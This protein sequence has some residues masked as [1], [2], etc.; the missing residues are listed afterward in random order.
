MRFI[1]TEIKDHKYFKYLFF[2]HI[3]LPNVIFNIWE[4]LSQILV[5]RF[6]SIEVLIVY[7]KW[8]SNLS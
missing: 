7:P 4:S 5:V 2:S 3:L 1:Y 6:L 8:K